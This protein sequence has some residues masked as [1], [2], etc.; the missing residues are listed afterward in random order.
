MRL[1]TMLKTCPLTINQIQ[2]QM[3]NQ[4][5]QENWQIRKSNTLM[6][7]SKIKMGFLT[8]WWIPKNTK[9]PESKYYYSNLNFI[10]ISSDRRMQNRESAVRSRLRKRYY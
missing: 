8:I 7:K 6:N 2:I 9:E 1:S 5:A 4:I 3:I 10:L